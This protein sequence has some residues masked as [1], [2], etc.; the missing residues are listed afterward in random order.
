MHWTNEPP[1]QEHIGKWFWM[2]IE[3]NPP[4]VVRVMLWG[5]KRTAYR[6]AENVCWLAYH[7]NP[8]PMMAEIM[9]HT[10]WAGPIIPPAMENNECA[11]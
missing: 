7:D 9:S 5:G 11:K 1:R 4:E 6:T 2:K 3:D 10:M 8:S